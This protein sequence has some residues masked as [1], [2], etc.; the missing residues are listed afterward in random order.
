G[1]ADRMLLDL[2]DASSISAFLLSLPIKRSKKKE[3][4]AGL[5]VKRLEQIKLNRLD[6]IGL[7]LR[8]RAREREQESHAAMRLACPL[9]VMCG[10][11]L[12]KNFLTLLQHWSGAVMCPACLCGAQAAGPNAMRGPG[13]YQNNALQSPLTQ[14]GSPDPRIDRICI[15]SSCPRQFLENFKRHLVAW[16]H[17]LESLW[18]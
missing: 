3:V 11:R 16:H 14:T 18:L 8:S 7:D 4:P 6:W 5:P 17:L 1:R 13:P 2:A 10:R 15:P 12:G 9:W